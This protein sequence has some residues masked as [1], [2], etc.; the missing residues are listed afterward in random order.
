MDT[1]FHGLMGAALC[2]RT[3][4]AGGRLG[5][6]SKQGRWRVVEWTFFAAIG[7]G[8]LPDLASLGIHHGWQVLHGNGLTFEGIPQ[9][10][11][12]LYDFFHSLAGISIGIGLLTWWKRG[13]LLPAL[14]WPLHVLADVPTH[15]DG[16]FATPLLWPFSRLGFS[17]WNWWEHPQIFIWGWAGMIAFWVALGV[18]RWTGRRRGAAAA[19]EQT[20]GPS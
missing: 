5:P 7:F 12:W 17:G 16:V 1:V 11:F 10:I 20:G 18:W 6:R 9:W 14:A 4:L 8:M 2:S 13:L 3:G 15:G 19:T